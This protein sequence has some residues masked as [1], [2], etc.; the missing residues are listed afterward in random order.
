MSSL[1][2][3]LLVRLFCPSV[4]DATG[5]ED[6]HVDEDQGD[7]VDPD[8]SLDDDSGAGDQDE[9]AEKPMSRAQREIITLRERAQKA[10]DQHRQAMADLESERRK[11]SSGAAKP[12]QEQALYDQEE[13]ILKSPEATDWQRYSVQ[14]A[15]DAR[16]ALAES[17]NATRQ[18]QDASD[19]AAFERLSQT[20][21][22]TFAAYK[23]KV[24]TML[25]D[26]RKSGNNAPREELMALLVGRDLLQGKAKAESKTEAKGSESRGR[27]P[28]VRTDTSSGG[29]KLSDAEKRAKR[30]ENVRI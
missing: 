1:L 9:P 13:A 6:S 18:S 30:L 8:D 23:D 5:D 29:G 19:K 26:M 21:P 3:S 10:E 2:K 20:K 25:A 11:Q 15:R 22:K 7:E 12:T 17:R 27:T 24:E 14:S 16:A 4:D 28:G